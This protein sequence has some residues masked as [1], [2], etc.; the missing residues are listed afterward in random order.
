MQY[1]HAIKAATALLLAFCS[2]FVPGQT[3]IA[4]VGLYQPGVKTPNGIGK[5]YMG[6]E[7]AHYMSHRG[8]PWLERNERE[9]EERPDLLMKALD[10]KPG[11]HVADIGCGSGY[12]SR[13]IAETVGTN[14]V[15]YGVDIQKEMLAI[16]HRNMAANNLTNYLAVLGTATDPMLPVAKLDLALFVDVYH[17]FD[18]PFE[19]M[20]K[21]CAALKP[22]G[23]IVLVEYR[24]EDP[25]VPIKLLHKMTEAQVKKEMK[26]Q[27]LRHVQTVTDLPWQHVIIFE[28]LGA[29]TPE[30]PNN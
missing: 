23:R 17:E 27:P 13:R 15:V 12:Y 11:M 26:A 18:H 16:L 6:R 5:Y 10:L 25:R 21:I 8:A 19:M 1:H 24:M 9:N 2:S 28:K 14:G 20:Q 3:A 4:A 7:L 29:Q 22:G 30:S